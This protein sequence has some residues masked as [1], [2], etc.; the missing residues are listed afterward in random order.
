MRY[1]FARFERPCCLG[2]PKPSLA[3]WSYKALTRE[4]HAGMRS[5]IIDS[6]LSL[7]P[8]GLLDQTCTHWLKQGSVEVRSAYHVVGSQVE[9]LD[10][11]CR[12]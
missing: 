12:S 11:S 3:R 6:P 9:S 1:R 2:N 5:F 10:K 7:D 4:N 8:L